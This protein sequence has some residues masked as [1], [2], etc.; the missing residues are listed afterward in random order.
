MGSKISNSKAFYIVISIVLSVS[1]W[2]YVVNV[3][4]PT[5]EITIRNIPITILGED[6]LGERGFMITD[7]SS[8]YFDLNLSGK[9]SALVKLSE[10]NITVTLDVS[11]IT[12]DGDWSLKCK[13]TL[14]STVTS[15]TVTITEKNDYSVSVT[16][17]KQTS[18]PIDI[19]GEFAGTVAEGYQADEFIISPSTVTVTGQ[20]DLVNQVAYGLVSVAQI[21]LN[22]TFTSEMGFT[23]MSATGEKLKDLNVQ[24]S[25]STVYVTLPIVKVAEIPLAVNIVD[26]GG[27]TGAD[28]TVTIDPTSIVVS[29]AQEV[30]TPLTKIT[31]GESALADVLS[32]ETFTFPLN[33][34]S[35]LTNESGIS[36]ATVTVQVA[37]L[38]S[39]VLDV[40]NIE[41]I[42]VPDGFVASAVTQSL[43]VWVR[44]PE[45][46]LDGISAYQVQAVADL[47]DASVSVGQFRVPVKLYLAG[48]G[49][50]GIVGADYSISI[51]VKRK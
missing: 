23:L 32:V 28:A 9:R 6:V 42:N 37:D 22:D 36:E 21:N 39:K 27:A 12:A 15:G 4:K 14:P 31:L 25:T 30:L 48:D 50:A 18:K 44:G 46:A 16:I 5:G 20:E 1:L 51:T 8:R 11:S 10:E 29:G 24:L 34:T 41:I 45:E 40:H 3:E 13:V 38:P 19:R 47:E 26:G 17:A 2:L 33:L 7:M 49:D 35:E 43:Q